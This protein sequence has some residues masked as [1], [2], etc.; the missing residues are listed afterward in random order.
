M[1]YIP[2]IIILGGHNIKKTRFENFDFLDVQCQ[3]L[4]K[5]VVY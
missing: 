5:Q 1:L 4:H 3:K 2:W